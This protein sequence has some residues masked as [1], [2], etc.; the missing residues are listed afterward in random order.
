MN[1]LSTAT[2]KRYCGMCDEWVH[3]R[4]CPRC[5]ADTDAPSPAWV[6]VDRETTYGSTM[7]LSFSVRVF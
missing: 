6:E 3:G 4:K 1:D 2:K 5:G 7:R